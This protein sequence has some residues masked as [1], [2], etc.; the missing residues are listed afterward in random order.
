MTAHEPTLT[1]RR[2]ERTRRDIV[3]A[4]LELVERDGFAATVVEDIADRA[5]VSV[6]S[7]YRYCS[8]KVDA[9]AGE[10]EQFPT[11]FAASL[12]AVDQEVSMVDAVSHSIAAAM[13]PPEVLVIRRRVIAVTL[14]E[15]QLRGRWLGAWRLTRLAVGDAVARRLPGA[16]G[17]HAESLAGAIVGALIVAA[18]VWAQNDS[19]ELID[20]MN[21]ALAVLQPAIAAV[22]KVGA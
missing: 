18:E 8:D 21:D 13:A 14:D 19:G 4:A 3:R 1:A 16:T 11:A 9:L 5:G 2:R 6:R 17:I 15:A 12:R 22:E 10:L 20:Y 7:F